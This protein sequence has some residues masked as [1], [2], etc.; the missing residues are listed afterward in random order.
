MISDQAIFAMNIS[1]YSRSSNRV[2]R[3]EEFNIIIRRGFL[4]MEDFYDWKRCENAER[5]QDKI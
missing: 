4:C 1:E 3:N 5:M 2:Q